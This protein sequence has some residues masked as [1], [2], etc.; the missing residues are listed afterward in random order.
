MKKGENLLSIA[1]KAC[2]KQECNKCVTAWIT[3]IL[4]NN[5]NVTPINTFHVEV[6]EDE[7]ANDLIFKCLEGSLP[8]ACTSNTCTGTKAFCDIQKCSTSATCI[9][10]VKNAKTNWSSH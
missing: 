7:R 10:H 5:Q 1:P 4:D 3:K 2:L 6:Q 9:C 8:C